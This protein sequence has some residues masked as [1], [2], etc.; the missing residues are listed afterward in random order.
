MICLVRFQG[1]ETEL[2]TRRTEP[3]STRILFHL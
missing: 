1:E 3:A 2:K